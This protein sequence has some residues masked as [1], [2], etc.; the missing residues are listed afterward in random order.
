MKSYRKFM[1]E[2][3]KTASYVVAA[4]PHRDI[5]TGFHLHCLFDREPNWFWQRGL[6]KQWS[7]NYGH[8]K[9]EKPRSETNVQQYVTKYV[10]KDWFPNDN[11]ATIYARLETTWDIHLSRHKRR[12]L[13]L[14]TKNVISSAGDSG[15]IPALVG[16][17][18]RGSISEIPN[19]QLERMS[20]DWKAQQIRG[21]YRYHRPKVSTA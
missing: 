16:L 21:W 2:H 20:F 7:D 15:S 11:E 14:P 18:Q 8:H 3:Y 1:R 9:I 12:Q 5:A 19:A 13:G 17:S 10:M 4:E 6:Q